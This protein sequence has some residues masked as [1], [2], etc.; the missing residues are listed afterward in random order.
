[1]TLVSGLLADLSVF[2]TCTLGISYWSALTLCG[3]ESSC[4]PD[5]ASDSVP[6][7]SDRVLRRHE[8]VYTFTFPALRP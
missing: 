2:G 5:L 7:H 8:P 1:M 6:I 4:T 3:I